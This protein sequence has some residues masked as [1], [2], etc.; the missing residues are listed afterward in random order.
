MPKEA[1]ECHV[2][3]SVPV[4]SR[5]LGPEKPT[6]TSKPRVPSC[7]YGCT[8]LLVCDAMKYSLSQ[9]TSSLVLMFCFLNSFKI[10]GHL[11]SLHI[12]NGFDTTT[13]PSYPFDSYIFHWSELIGSEFPCMLVAQVIFLQPTEF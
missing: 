1:S 6:L 5:L 11:C 13:W 7:R 3:S 4:L 8:R 2:L 9:Q 10:T 12:G